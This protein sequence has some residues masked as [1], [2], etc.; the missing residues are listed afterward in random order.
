MEKFNLSHKM[1]KIL[2]LLLIVM[3]TVT[4]V[5]AQY[6]VGDYYEKDGLKG[7]VVRIDDSG[8]HGLI[9]SL[10]KSAKKWLDGGDEKF[11]TN[12]YFEDDG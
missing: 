1:K 6:K 2:L 11:S 12:A 10:E 4:T 5:N 8:N 3:G 7:I 9:M